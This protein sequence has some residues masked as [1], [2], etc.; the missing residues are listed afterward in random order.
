MPDEAG[1]A[2]ISVAY[3]PASVAALEAETRAIG[4]KV[5]S[6]LGGVATRSSHI[7]GGL[8]GAF[9]TFE[10]GKGI[11]EAIKSAADF[12]QQ[13]N[14]LGVISHGTT[15]QLAAARAEAIRL[16]QDMRLPATT[17]QTAAEAIQELVKSGRSLTSAMAGARPVLQLATGAQ[18]SMAD[19]AK[20]AATI[21]NQFQLGGNQTKHVVDILTAATKHSVGTID[22]FA[23]SFRYAGSAA[24][25]ARFSLQDTA[26]ALAE[27]ANRGI[28]GS[29]AGT[30]LAQAIRQ[31][32]HPSVAAAAELKTLGINVYDLHGRMK[33]LPDLIE[34]FSSKVNNLTDKQK[35]L[36]LN[37]IFTARSIQ[38]ARFVL[39]GGIPAYEKSAKAL[40]DVGITA[41]LARARTAGFAGSLNALQSNV[42]T[43]GIQLGTLLLPAA[44]K[45]VGVLAD[46]ARGVQQIVAAP[47]LKIAISI[48]WQ[49]VGKVYQSLH[50]MILGESH[51]ASRT[52]GK[53]GAAHGVPVPVT[54]D[55]KGIAAQLG[56][57][58]SNGIKST[59]WGKIGGEIGSHLASAIKFTSA[60]ASTLVKSLI[61][62]LQSNAPELGKAGALIFANMVSTLLDPAFWIK[63]WDLAISIGLAAFPE[64][65][66]AEGLGLVLKGALELVGRPLAEALPKIL[67][68]SV[69][70]SGGLLKS[71]FGFLEGPAIGSFLKKTLGGALGSIGGALGDAFRVIGEDSVA[72]GLVKGLISGLKKGG[73]L[74]AKG[75]GDAFRAAAGEVSG[76][77]RL[78]GEFLIKPIRDVIG[79]QIP[80]EFRVAFTEV[81]S[82]IRRAVSTFTHI[83]GTIW[84]AIPRLARAAFR[85]A[86]D[87]GRTVFGRM[88]QIGRSQLS[89]IWDTFRAA[90]LRA[91]HRITGGVF[92]VAHAIEGRV[93]TSIHDVEGDFSK[94]F[95][96]VQAVEKPVK[97]IGQGVEKVGGGIL[98][99]AGRAGRFFLKVAVIK[100]AVDGVATGFQ[101]VYTWVVGVI[102]K[103]EELIGKIASIHFPSIPGGGFLS[104]VVSTATGGAIKPATGGIVT[105]G[106]PG[107]DSVPALLTPGEVVLN[108]DQQKALLHGGAGGAPS[109]VQVFIG[110]E[111]LDARMIRVVNKR[112]RQNGRRLQAGRVW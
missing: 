60:Q 102:H 66:L 106:I 43:L 18:I 89:K 82:V 73:G 14:V 53:F 34:L 90:G 15:A 2:Y 30:A 55:N 6:T 29:I 40:D 52:G 97:D 103:V 110:S 11:G 98:R 12:Q 96:K 64:G 46:L 70:K 7:L 112:E 59:D 19:A 107:V 49:G 23:A 57:A 45:V 71:L 27:L 50:D 79:K 21:L 93:A 92:E 75:L 62:G 35:N 87:T 54:I 42:E 51:V 105:G 26:T 85:V 63:N 4:G 67:G 39:A 58:L 91:F 65:K 101:T 69:G 80:E 20:Y 1:R 32:Q 48:A 74:I 5:T 100:T 41:R 13:M 76:V 88:V 10:I 56:D 84:T 108:M 8:L 72:P 37:T 3:D 94:L 17:A 25:G 78:I 104:S 47:S 31:L 99:A 24:H 77:G 16:G 36:A 86:L 68:E 111:Q 44:T 109:T 22:D 95:Q 28:L 83:L 38:A 81:G 9:A 33:S 61:S